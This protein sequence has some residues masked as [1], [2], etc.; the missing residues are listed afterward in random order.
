MMPFGNFHP[1]V[2]LKEE[3]GARDMTAASLALKIRVP[4]QRLHEIIR[5]N[6]AITPETA[7]RLALYFGNEPEFWMNLQMQYDLAELRKAKGA[8]IAAEV[9]R[10]A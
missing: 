4:P 10:A 3:L 6:R 5:G 1:G 7:L 9:E 8:Q 2:T